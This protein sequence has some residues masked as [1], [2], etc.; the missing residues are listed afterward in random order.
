MRWILNL[1]L[2]LRV[3]VVVAMAALLIAGLDLWRRT[4]MDVFPEFAPP[5]IEIQTEAPG[6][7]PQQVET[8]V[9]APIENALNGTPWLETIRSTSVPG[10]SSVVLFFQ[11]G[12][13]LLSARQLVQE[14]LSRVSRLLPAVAHPPVM[15]APIS[16]TGRILMIG[17]TSAR[18]SRMDL[19]ALARWTV[20]PRLLAV[21][22]VANVSIWGER[23][24]QFQIQV[25]PQQLRAAGLTLDE[26]EQAG[27]LATRLANG[28]FLDTPNQR[29]VINHLPAVQTIQDLTSVPVK[30]VN[31]VPLL[32]GQVARLREGYPPPIGD[33]VINDT[34]G[35]LL[36][37]EKQPWANTLETTRLLEEALA[38]LKPALPDVE[39][40][41]HLFRP[42][43]FI[44]MS[45]N[46][47]NRALLI[48]C[49]LV[50]IVLS[51]FLYNW[52][53][54]LIS[55]LALPAS[56]IVAGIL[57]H[58]Q[59]GTVN[60]MILAGLA[61]A[62]GEVV[63]DAI[64][65]VENI[66]R[67]LR[68]HQASRSAFRV[69]LEASLEVRSAVVFGS[70]IVVLVLLPV[71]FL[72]GLAGT[73]FRPLAE[74]YVLAILSSLL[75][76]LTLTPAL[77][78]LLL[79]GSV[80][81]ERVS[82]LVQRLRAAYEKWLQKSLEASQTV[83]LGL[84]GLFVI[85]VLL[86][87]FLKEEFL[88]RFREYDFLMH[89]VEKP[90]T[91]LQAMDR[92][93][94]R[95]SKELRSIP[96]VKHFA[97]HIGRAELGEETVATNFGELWISV[98]PSV[99][100]QE[101]MEKVEQAVAG[102]PGLY[103]DVLTF[104]RER[105]EEVLTGTSG[106]IVVRLYGPDLARLIEKA[107]QIRDTLRTIPHISDLAVEQIRMVPQINIRFRPD[108]GAAAGLTAG[109]V[110]E[111]VA[112]FLQGAR[113]GQVYRDQT[114][115]DVVVTGV[116][117]LRNNLE[118]LQNLLLR[119]PAGG[120][121]PLKAVAD[122]SIE[123]SPNAITREGASR[124]IDISCN[125]RGGNLNRVAR[126]V[127]QRV[128]ALHYEP[129]YHPEVLGEF[130]AQQAARNRLLSLGLLSLVGVFLVL[131]TDFQSLHLSVLVLLGLPLA[132][133]GGVLGVLAGGGVLSLGSIIGFITVLGVAARN[134]IM[135]IAHYRH[136]QREEG[137]PFGRA[138]IIRGA[139]ERLS[140]ILMTAL[141]TALALLPIALGGSRPGQE[142]EHP[143]ALV[144][145]GGLLTSTVL[146][147][148]LL[149][150]LYQRFGRPERGKG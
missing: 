98:D 37:V 45:L 88:P 67:R 96:G 18:L 140:P 77:A 102:Y 31:G 46:N 86:L 87:P 50:V 64:I 28:G 114:V 127:E 2:R 24:R 35:V 118:A 16:S 34:T 70:M 143:M 147:L 36:V 80:E 5:R 107:E 79:P 120:Y 61:I 131:Y 115:I 116:P 19:S 82:P 108:R 137:M 53:S 94:M 21:P 3:V 63:D 129:G 59:G 14:R 72:T 51:F 62:L 74:S 95:L 124:K 105:I 41:A 128:A 39:I 42:A 136:L 20:L 12:T 101:T 40:D 111:A 6:L 145:L 125:V 47:L 27:R 7:S 112:T 81:R 99:D 135:L 58:Y 68:E 9:S 113:V 4:P 69:V 60:T 22:G 133:T 126:E 132:L 103:H 142:I 130:K 85:S 54:A 29:L 43:T 44:E 109:Q 78:L 83:L 32:L 49:V 23:P 11:Q 110:R 17:M 71:F 25:D 15:L 122:V 148:F 76:A 1:S 66:V 119:T 150:L 26:V 75:V 92:L 30:Y 55:A 106:S 52:R 38:A 93:V 100:Y 57:L 139:S 97:G 90:S 123:P 144:I 89:W 65:D 117:E 121:L 8:L 134:G 141:T 73:F 33:A 10:L 149:P 13:D 48:G 91:S 146:N 84:G 104:L 56:L 138:L